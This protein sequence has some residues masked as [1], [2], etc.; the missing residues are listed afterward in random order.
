MNTR[1][2]GLI[3]T[4]MLAVLALV[5][6][7]A[8]E[9]NN[10]TT[11][12][13]CA[14]VIGDG[15]SGHDA[16]IHKVVYPGDTVH[17]GQ[18]EDIK[19]FPCNSRNYVINS[20]NVKNANRELVGDRP[21]LSVGYTKQHTKILLGV[22]AYWTLNQTRSVLQNEFAPLCLKYNCWSGDSRSGDANFSTPGWNGMLAENFGPSIDRTVVEVSSEFED[23]LWSN[24]DAELR[25]K[26]ETRLSKEF[27]ANVQATTGYTD[28]LFCGSG[29]SGWSDPNRPGRGKYN[30]TSVRFV[31]TS[32]EP[33]D[34]TLRDQTT[35][36]NAKQAQ[37]NA[38]RDEL[39]IAKA[40][41]GDTASYWLGVQDAL[42]ACNAGSTCVVNIGG[43]SISITGR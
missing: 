18:Y 15:S 43:S 24:Q 13:K 1:F 35:K 28:D 2:K 37:K 31:I 40:K 34:K 21:N 8:C 3:V 42:G 11:T 26:F 14:F 36:V 5:G 41:Y 27:A 33:S 22:T 38:N 10:A 19:Y 17:V 9:E 30:C 20:G 29:N 12:D 7:S 6:L 39:D 16:R 4:A 23:A 25:K 32:V